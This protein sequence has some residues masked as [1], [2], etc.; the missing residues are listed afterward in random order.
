MIQQSS[1]S[2]VQAPPVW[3]GHDLI[4]LL[5]LQ[6]DGD[7][8]FVTRFSDPNP[9]GRV[10]G[11]QILS[12]AL[13]AAG[14]DVPRERLPTTLQ[15]MFLQGTRVEEAVVMNVRA[16][17][18]GKRF[19]SRHV[20][21]AQESGKRLVLDGQ[22]TFATSMSGPTHHMAPSNPLPDP[23]TQPTPDQ[24][25]QAWQDDLKQA[26]GY[27]MHVSEVLE[28]RLNEPPPRLIPNKES[29]RSC[30]WMR[31]RQPLPNDPLL[32]AAAFTFLSDWWINF[33][34]AAP[35]LDEVL[36]QGGVYVVSLNHAIW[37]HQPFSPN[38]WLHFDVVSPQGGRG[39]GL[40][41]GRVHTRDGRLVASVTQESLLAY[42]D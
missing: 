28:F 22:F 17:Q 42:R 27:G 30:F 35:H 11:G 36:A 24:I 20:S 4:D 26:L 5:T 38:E 21:G 8:R 39:R 13:M 40:A 7:H 15:F 29:P 10:Y 19:S 3:N 16:L 32:H 6:P 41:V 33:V 9:N 12:Q 25:P 23:E 37:F 1:S 18:D 34:T 2:D 14:Q 31:V